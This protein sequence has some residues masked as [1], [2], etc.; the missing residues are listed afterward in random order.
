MSLDK[1]SQEPSNGSSLRRSSRIRYKPEYYTCNTKHG[2]KVVKLVVNHVMKGFFLSSNHDG[3]VHE[4]LLDEDFK[5]INKFTMCSSFAL[6]ARK[7]KY[8]YTTMFNKAISVPHREEL[9]KAM[10]NEI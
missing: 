9:M 2:Y 4:M 7:A 1:E 3:Y 8:P 6:T 10:Y 5:N